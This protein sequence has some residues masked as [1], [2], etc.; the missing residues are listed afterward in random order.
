MQRSILGERCDS[1]PG[2]IPDSAQRRYTPKGPKAVKYFRFCFRPFSFSRRDI[3]PQGD[4]IPLL[5]DDS[6]RLIVD[7]IARG[8]IGSF[9]ANTPR[10]GTGR[11]RAARLDAGQIGRIGRR[12]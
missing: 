12:S 6:A 5:A 10:V 1:S 11:R 9:L 7:P 3:I 4:T 8:G 2:S